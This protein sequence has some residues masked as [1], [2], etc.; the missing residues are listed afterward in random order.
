MTTAS[1]TPLILLEGRASELARCWK[2]TVE[3]SDARGVVALVVMRSLAAL[4]R[5]GV[6]LAPILLAD[7]NAAAAASQDLREVPLPACRNHLLD[8]PCVIRR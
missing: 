2:L 3:V 4:A 5:T 1:A 8:S 6:R 7:L